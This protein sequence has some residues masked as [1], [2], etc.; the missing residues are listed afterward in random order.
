VD[1]PKIEKKIQ[2]T[3]KSKSNLK[4]RQP[5]NCATLFMPVLWKQK[6]I[7]LI[8]ED[9]SKFN[10]AQK[11]FKWLGKVIETHQNKKLETC[12]GCMFALM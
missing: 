3:G 11:T 7:G 5:L 8:L 10:W 12:G 6:R 9:P 4:R 2:L 1:I